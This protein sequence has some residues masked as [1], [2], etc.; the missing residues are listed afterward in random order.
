V[1]PACAVLE[2]SPS[3]YYA[4]KKR[5]ENPSARDARDEE[6]KEEIM[7]V[8]K[9]KGRRLYG[10][11][12]VWHELNRE[13]VAVARCTV[14]RL[15]GELGIAGA[16]AR[17][18]RPRTTVPAEPGHER[19]SDLLERDFTAPAPN[20][21]W[22]ADI[23]YVETVAGFVYASFILDLHSRMIAGW[24][25]ADTLRAELALDA[26]EMAIWSRGDRIDG[27]LVHHSDRGVQYTSIRYTERLG[28]ISAV[29]SVGRKGDSYDN[30][31][32]ESLNSLYKKEL[33]ERDGPWRGTDDVMLAT[34]EW[35]SW[36]NTERLH[37][38]CG[39]VPPKEYEE[40]YCAR[41]ESMVS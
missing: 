20:R 25:V 5:E 17:K 36:Y 31:A 13:G 37:S 11:K 35:V 34:M 12:K 23:T 4:A 30:A 1:E 7:R 6:L 41:Q 18:K 39:Y 21:R 2:I 9:G 10:A 22:V 24:Q 38:A 33:I 19:P 16:A 15:M 14:E 26:L 3:T 28:E 40:G 8:W 32:A 27:Q 29:R